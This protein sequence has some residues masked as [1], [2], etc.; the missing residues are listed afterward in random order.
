MEAPAHRSD[1]RSIAIAVAAA[2]TFVGSIAASPD[3]SKEQAAS[4]DAVALV[5]KKATASASIAIVRGGRI[6]YASATGERDLANDLPA[7]PQT[8]YHIGSITKLFTA[9]SV[10]Q[11]V[12]AGRISLDDKLSRFF[13]TFPNGANISIRELLMHRSGIPN[14]LDSAVADAAVLKPTTPQAIVAWAASQPPSFAPGTAYA[15][16]N[17]NYVLLGLIVEQVA[18]MPLRAYYA[19]HIFAPAGMTQT[20]VGTAPAGALQWWRR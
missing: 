5:S 20:Y 13:P 4:L 8:I 11:L 19:Q 2:L 1:M 14:Y 17:T 12:E 3:L 16:S 9:V 10:M 7:T 6:V 18:K 15:Y